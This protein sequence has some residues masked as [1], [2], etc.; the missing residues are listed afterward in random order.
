ML[1]SILA[2]QMGKYLYSVTWKPLVFLARS[3]VLASLYAPF[4]I[5]GIAIPIISLTTLL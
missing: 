4:C 2:T 3:P 5:S 1:G